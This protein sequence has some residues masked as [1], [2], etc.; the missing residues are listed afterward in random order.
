[1]AITLKGL[2][3]AVSLGGALGAPITPQSSRGQT[4]KGKGMHLRCL[5]AAERE[6]W[7][8]V[9]AKEDGR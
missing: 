3:C 5:T 8:K 9:E 4:K 2:V 7:R 1:M 6:T